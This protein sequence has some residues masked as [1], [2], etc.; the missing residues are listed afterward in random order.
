MNTSKSDWAKAR[1]AYES[2]APIPYDPEDG[3]YDPNDPVATAKFFEEA[4]SYGARERA[5]GT[6]R[7][8]INLSNSVIEYFAAQGDDWRER[9]NE[10]LKAH[11]EAQTK[12]SPELA[13]AS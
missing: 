6:G 13:K 1:E 10:V 8:R 12:Q 3:P 11:V 2:G 4:V 9:I 7:L 5:N